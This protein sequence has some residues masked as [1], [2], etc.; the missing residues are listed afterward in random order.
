MRCRDGRIWTPF[1]GVVGSL[2]GRSPTTP[3]PRELPGTLRGKYVGKPP[4]CPPLLVGAANRAS[5][6][7]DSLDTA[8]GLQVEK[9]GRHP[10]A[11]G[12]CSSDLVV[13]NGRMTNWWTGWSVLI[14]IGVAVLV[15]WLV[16]LVALWVGRP[17]QLSLR[18][19]LRL[20]PDIARLLHRLAADKTL[21]RGVRIRL[22]LLLAYLAIPI[23]PI[24]DFI[25]VIGYADDA[26]VVAFA[27]RS[28]TRH[29]G[30]DALE[31]HWPG[32]PDGLAA[33]RRLARLPR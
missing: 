13:E 20:L 1:R 31:R 30:G 19:A 3:S 11:L 16:L 9:R 5:T 10:L 32:T 6:G 26:I 27:L 8:Q 14:S 24:P 33:V 22:W 23:D 28:V 7:T 25:P 17:D 18:D 29:A 15:L 21:P 12:I 4:A 2:S